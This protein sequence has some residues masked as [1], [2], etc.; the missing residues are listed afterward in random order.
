[1]V[2]AQRAQ[3]REGIL[4]LAPLVE[5]GATDQLIAQPIAQERL[6][7]GP[8]LGVRPVH[9]RDVLEP[10]RVVVA[11]I[12]PTCEDRPGRPPTGH[13]RFHL[14]RDPFRLLV[15][16]V[17]LE[18]LD[19]HAPG[20]LRPELLVLAVLVA[21]HDRMGGIEDELGG[22]VV[23]LQLDDRGIGVVTFEVKDVAQ[24]GAAPGVDALVVITH[25]RQ[26][27]MPLGKLAD[28][29]VLRPVRVLVLV[30]VEVPPAF[31]VVPQDVGSLVEQA[32]RFVEQVIE[33]EGARLLEPRRVSDVCA[34]VDLLHVALG[35]SGG[36]RRIHQ[37]VLPATDR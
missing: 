17:R 21:G 10:V 13:Q 34:R 31:L 28:P 15:L 8:A 18:P 37:V 11:V 1:M 22:A 7:D 36:G 25:H 32:D 14:A 20:V 12:R 27:V 16:P 4:D 6:L 26:V 23:L 30:D 19:E 35:G 29:Q 2:V 5:A 33:V 24:V 3:V 9:D